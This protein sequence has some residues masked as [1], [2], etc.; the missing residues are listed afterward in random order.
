MRSHIVGHPEMLIDWCSRTVAADSRMKCPLP[1]P[2]EDINSH[3]VSIRGYLWKVLL[4]L[5]NLHV[6]DHA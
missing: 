5:G 3:T 2:I 4:I 1:N 6:N